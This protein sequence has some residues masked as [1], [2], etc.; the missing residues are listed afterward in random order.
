MSSISKEQV[1]EA[2]SSIV[3]E[4]LGAGH[5]IHIPGL[6][7]FSVEHQPS[8]LESLEDG[9]MV[10]KPPRDVVNFLPDN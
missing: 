8:Q 3:R 9:E 7:T 4:S 2:L 5:A 6:G 10:I 1:A